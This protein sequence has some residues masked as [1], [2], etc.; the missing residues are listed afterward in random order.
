MSAGARI[1]RLFSTA[2][3]GQLVLSGASFVVGLLLIRY[4]SDADYGTFVLAQTSISLMLTAQAAWVSG[5]LA[6][7]AAKRPPE[8]RREMIGTVSASVQRYSLWGCGLALLV[9]P[10]GHVL[11]YWSVPVAMV[12]LLTIIACWFSMQREFFRNLLQLY[13]RSSS[14]LVVDVVSSVAII[15]F[16]VAAAFGPL[17]AVLVAVSGLIASG[18]LGTR[19]ARRMVDQDPGLVD[20]GNPAVYWQ[21]MRPLAMWATTGALIYWVFSQSYN[22]VLAARVD[23]SAVADVNAARLLLMPAIVLTIGIRGQLIPM[24]ARWLVD[25]GLDRLLKRLLL[26]FAAVALLQVGYFV[27]LWIARDWLTGTLLNTVI[28]NREQLLLLWGLIAMIGLIREVA[29]AAVQAMEKFKAMAYFTAAS[30]VVSLTVMW[31]GLDHW[32]P[33]AVLIGQVAGELIGLGGIAY[34]LISA[35]R[36]QAV[37]GA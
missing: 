37:A 1:V 21:Q 6:V 7:L 3:V 29:Q 31:F 20:T 18:W 19:L 12:A 11:G 33:P 28:G 13:A 24:A 30:A 2:V 23:L 17:Q 8:Q 34:L 9:P 35:R 27:V 22:Y 5:P 16:A 36:Q 14:L 26:F 4:T 15:V 32:G 25:L 10:I